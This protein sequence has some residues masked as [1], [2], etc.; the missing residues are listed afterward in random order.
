MEEKYT[1]II[2]KALVAMV[3]I[4]FIVLTFYR[5]TIRDLKEEIY[6][7][8]EKLN[9]VTGPFLEDC[10]HGAEALENYSVVGVYEDYNLVCDKLLELA[11]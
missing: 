9:M 6:E 7:C 4:Q 2:F 8:V 11:E 10:T 1:R 3:I 5:W